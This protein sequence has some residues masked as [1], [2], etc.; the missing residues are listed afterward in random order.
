MD[1]NELREVGKI[2]IL[3]GVFSTCFFA[4]CGQN[5]TSPPKAATPVT[6]TKQG[7]HDLVPQPVTIDQEYETEDTYSE[8]LEGS[9]YSESD[10]GDFDQDI[11]EFTEDIPRPAELSEKPDG[12][13]QEVSFNIPE[14]QNA[15]VALNATSGPAPDQNNSAEPQEAYIPDEENQTDSDYLT[16][17]AEPAEIEDGIVDFA[18]EA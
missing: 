10:F 9:G 6:H 15:E 3:M 18:E 14:M 2:W 11:P 7:I 8:D 4:S 5:P 16:F 17:F 13:A 12:E 1:Y